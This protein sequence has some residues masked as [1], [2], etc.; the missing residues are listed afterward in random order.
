MRLALVF[1][2]LLPNLVRASDPP[3]GSNCYDTFGGSVTEDEV[4]VDARYMKQHLLARV[5]QQAGLY[6]LERQ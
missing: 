3:L 4:L 1:A 6:R 5:M 2:S